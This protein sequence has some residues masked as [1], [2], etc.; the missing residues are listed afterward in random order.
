MKRK[1]IVW[2]I[3]LASVVFTNIL[4][5]MILMPLSPTIKKALEMNEKQ[6]GL[7]ISVYLFSA[8]IAGLLSIFIIDRFDRKRFLIS[9]YALFIIG[10]L[11]CGLATSYE[12]LLF[13]RIMAGF[14]GGVIG[15][16]VM[17]IVGDLVAP[18][19]RGKATGIVMT[20]FSSAAG[21]GIPLGL[22][23]GHTWNWHTPFFV[24]A[25]MSLLTLVFLIIVLP[26]V[27]GHLIE[28]KKHKSY[29]I[30]ITVWQ[31]KDQLKGLLFTCTI[32][33]GQFAIIPYLADFMVYNVGFKE[34]Q[35]VWM[36]F[37]GGILT[38]ITNPF[39][40]FLADKHGQLKTFAIVMALSL[41]PIAVIPHLGVTPLFI[42]LIFST[43]FFVF[44][45]GRN[46]PGTAIVLGTA[47]PHER[48][49][50]MSLRSAFQ[51]LAGGVAVL[52][53]S[54]VV[55][56]HPNGSYENFEYVGYIAIITSILSYIILRRIKQTF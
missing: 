1:E 42:T 53:G 22:W 47:A 19:H 3:L 17:A 43:L 41:I 31:N 2:M 38:F 6:W 40:G 33:F 29:E 13:A 9:Q 20:G 50:Y 51:Q 10:T 21:L 16:V 36:Y 55:T 39:I 46:I 34:S 18:E 25:G 26:R 54:W 52:L 5:S 11:L 49:G 8:F 14:F 23:L 28:A 27:N 12:F 56:Q 44:A 24:I 15:A 37:F 45:G 7:A 48:G 4:E 32:L 35:L 30:L